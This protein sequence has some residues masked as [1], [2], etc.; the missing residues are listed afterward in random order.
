MHP[1]DGISL[2]CVDTTNHALALRALD[3]SRRGARFAR[4]ML[5]TDSLPPGL[6]VPAGIEIVPVTG[7]ASRAAYSQFILKSLLAHVATPHVLLVQWDGYVTNPDAWDPAF[8]DCDYIGAQWFWHDDGMRVG[9]GGFSLRSRRLLEAL[10][11]ERIVAGAAEDETICRTYRPLLEREYG[12]R[13]ADEATADRF[14]FEA[15]YPVGRPFGFHGLYNFCRVMPPGELAALAPAFSDPIARSPQLAQLLRNCY[16]LGQWPAAI[17]IA[18]RILTAQ[19]D[20][21]EARTVVAQ[22][23]HGAAQLPAV[24]RNDPCPCGNGSGKRYKHCH[25]APNVAARSPRQARGA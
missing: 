11:D 2:C 5:L 25:G 22:A 7:I 20:N 15:A 4:V 24:G 19:P 23:Q 21:G 6:R 8:L 16:A 18:Q 10:Q 12:I 13:F 3:L 17:A 9:N 14:A 1:F